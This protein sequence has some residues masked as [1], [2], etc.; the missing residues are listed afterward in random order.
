MTMYTPQ[1]WQKTA[2][3]TSKAAQILYDAGSYRDCASRAYYAAYQAATALCVKHG[4]AVNFPPGWNNPAHEQLPRLIQQNGDLPPKARQEI[5]KS[6][7][8]LRNERESADY[9]LGQTVNKA[10]AQECL[11]QLTR[12]QFYLE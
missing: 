2:L 7:R 9:K 12:V 8:F 5:S 10:S 1:Q 4:D 11:R 3:E 6:L